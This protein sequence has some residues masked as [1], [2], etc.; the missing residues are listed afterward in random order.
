MNREELDE[1]L[2]LHKLWL[3]TDR[4]EGVRADLY[5]ANLNRASLIE[6]NLE[7]ANLEGAN[8]WY[9]IGNSREIITLQNRKYHINYTRDRIQIGCENHSIEEWKEF[10]DYTIRI[11][12]PG[13][14]LTWWKEHKDWLFKAIELNPAN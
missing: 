2:R 5:G 1:V 6:A 14:S 12:D 8:L 4:K 7:G 11:M 13:F 10:D 3:D 9:T